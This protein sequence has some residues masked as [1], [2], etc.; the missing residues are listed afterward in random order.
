MIARLGN[1]VYWICSGIAV[2]CLFG[3]AAVIAGLIGLYQTSMTY[4]DAAFVTGCFL[5]FAAFS[6]GIGRA[7]RYILSGI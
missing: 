5:G 4:Q 3:A 1:V 6:W 2:M 7:S